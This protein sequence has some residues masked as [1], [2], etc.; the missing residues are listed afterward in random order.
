MIITLMRLEFLMLM[1][2][3]IFRFHIFLLNN[4]ILILYYLVF[5]VCESVL[6]LTMLILL[7]R[8]YGNDNIKLINLILW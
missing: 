1:I 5:V 4:L 3:L 2:L 6:G 8:S 7:I